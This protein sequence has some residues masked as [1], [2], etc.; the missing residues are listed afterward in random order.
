VI[1]ELPDDA[2]LLRAVRGLRGRG[3]TRL[4]AYTPCI[5]DGL[6]EALGRRW[7]SIAIAT[8]AGGLGG[9]I[10]GY[11]L[12]WLLAAYLYPV[13]SGLRPPH[14][15]LAF[16]PIGIEMG[17]LFGA[18]VTFLAVLAAARLL[19]PWHP[20]FEVPGFESASRDGM[21]LAVD[22]SDPRFDAGEVASVIER[23][24]GTTPSPFGDP[25]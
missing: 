7:S 9:A 10:G 4:E 8:A 24:G 15:P 20:V 11:G 2:A 25:S 1:A 5:V 18:L 3:L 23:A 22:R 6:D 13:H 21:W 14:M 12:E 19:S 16:V 17:F